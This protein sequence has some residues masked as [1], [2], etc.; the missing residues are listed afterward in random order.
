MPAR[1]MRGARDVA[2]ALLGAILAAL[3]LLS[4]CTPAPGISA[5]SAAH[6]HAAS[7]SPARA[8]RPVCP[9]DPGRTLDVSFV[10][11]TR[12]D[13]ARAAASASIPSS[14]GYH[15]YLTPNQVAQQFGPDP[16]DVAWAEAVV[17]ATGLILTSPDPEGVLLNARGTVRQINTLLGIRLIE[18]RAP[19]GTSTFA[20]DARPRIPAAFGGTVTGVL[21]LDTRVTMHTGALSAQQGALQAL[22]AQGYTPT[23]LEAAYDL[24]PLRQAGLDGSKQT[25][26]L[27]E[28]DRF[29]PADV[30]AF[31][32]SFGITAPAPQVVRVNGGASSTSPEPA[33]DI[34]VVQA[35]APHANILVYESPKD[36]MSVARM[37]SRIVSDN[38]AQVLSISLGTC[39]RGLD[40]SIAQPFLSTLNN[41]FQRGAGQGMSVLV[42][43]GD[44]GAYDC[45]DNTLSVGAVA[46][47][48]YVTAVGGTALFLS[49]TGYGHEAGWEGPL[50]GAGSGGGIS[51]LYQRPS[52]QTGPGVDNQ[53]SDGNRQ[54]PDV[55]ADADPL[56][57]Y[58]IYYSTGRC[59]GQSCW[60]LIGGTSAATPLWAAIILLANQQA[61]Q[62]GK[63]PLGFLDPALYSLGAR[64][65]FGQIFHDVNQGGNLYYPATPRWDYA[66]GWGTPDGA[67]LVNGLLGLG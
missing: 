24:G 48:P 37:L 41:A 29:N 57:G 61:Q 60:Q 13:L 10:L 9:L 7:P 47:N 34:E 3:A 19:S 28:I 54:V 17:R 4:V 46:A 26:A 2:M 18:Y 23:D 50:E 20:P 66:T 14:P 21:G 59:Q 65:P 58:L 44:S 15:E 51:I 11:R 63:P 6:S 38:R 12:G 35:I 5:P 8:F 64:A 40:P 56:T 16:A 53:F 27:A 36:L 55:S 22:G 45:Q 25:I 62:R 49:G 30:Q 1:R 43:S 67:R 39:E 31:D 32:Q 52:W 42:A 33:L